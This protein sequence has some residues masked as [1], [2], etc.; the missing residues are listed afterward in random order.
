MGLERQRL[1]AI[2]KELRALSRWVAWRSSSNPSP[3]QKPRKIP[4]NPRDGSAASSTDPSTWGT[5]EEAVRCANARLL[6]GVGFMLEGSGYTGFDWDHCRDSTTGMIDEGAL[7]DVTVLGSYAEV[8]PSGLGLR[9]IARGKLPPGGRKKKSVEMYDSGRYL[10]FTGHTLDGVPAGVEERQAQIN[11]LHSKYFGEPK[12]APHADKGEQSAPDLELDDDALVHRAFMAK[13]GPKFRALWEGRIEGYGS[14]SEADLALCANL[15]FWTGADPSR[16]DRLFR[17]S[18]LYREKWDETHGDQTYGAMTIAKAMSSSRRLRGAATPATG[19]RRL[20]DSGNAERL[21]DR[22]GPDLRYCHPWKKFLVWKGGRWC[23]DQEARALGFSKH[24]ARGLYG[25]ASKCLD[26][27]QREAIAR[28][29]HTS[30]KA[31]RRRAMVELVRCEPGIPVLPG[32]LDQHPFKLNCANLTLDLATGE[33]YEHRRE[34]CLT[35][36]CPTRYEPSAQCP[37]FLAFLERVQPDDEVRAYLKRFFGYCLC[38]DVGEQVLGVSTGEGANGKSVLMGALQH[39]LSP[40]YAIQIPSDLLLN[41]DQRGHP[42]EIA[43]LFGVRLAIGIET[44]K[45]RALDESLVKQ[46]TGGDRLRARRMKENFW[47]FD[48]THKLVLVTNHMPSITASDYAMIRRLHVVRFDVTIP[49]SERDRKLP[50]KLKSEREGIL[51]WLVEGFHEWRERGLDPPSSVL[52]TP[53]T[54]SSPRTPVEEFVELFIVRK[55]GARTRATVLF[56]AFLHWCAE[57]GSPAVSQQEFGSYLGRKGFGRKKTGGTYVYLDLLLHAPDGV[58]KGR[59]GTKG[60]TLPID[61]SAES[62]ERA[63]GGSSPAGPQSSL[64]AGSAAQKE[65]EACVQGNDPVARR[66]VADSRSDLFPEELVWHD[67]GSEVGNGA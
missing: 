41:R 9:A 12:G 14:Q 25:E 19:S 8:S 57:N 16:M 31:E 63:N 54:A 36:L 30:E 28:W 59:L 51:V 52:W 47:E 11:Q 38:G 55:L 37:R 29:A 17:R 64:F 3:G 33:V 56:D 43:D 48:P 26:P 39:T 27:N 10:T 66:D 61:R 67:D 7:A 58:G 20:T 45:G 1:D 46:L 32:Q 5:F 24:I 2:P 42:T 21:V 62:H 22:F 4:V 49:D 35:R 44:P 60:T 18:G 34:D 40:D 23:S 65:Q 50:G 13:N 6:A 53:P 15:A